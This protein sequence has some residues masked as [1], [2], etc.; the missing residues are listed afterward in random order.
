MYA[1]RSYYAYV[2]PEE[3]YKLTRCEVSSP[4][5]FVQTDEQGCI[6]FSG[7]YGTNLLKEIADYAVVANVIAQDNHFDIIHAHDWLTYPAGI[8]SYNFV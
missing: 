1:I 3:F 8:A 2:D 5:T 6:Q 7:T 4:R